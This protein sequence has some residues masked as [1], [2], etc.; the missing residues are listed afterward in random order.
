MEREARK[1]W[2]AQLLEVLTAGLG[3]TLSIHLII[4]R[5]FARLKPKVMYDFDK[6]V[7]RHGTR[8][9]K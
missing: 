5:N 4:L 8:Y 2:R 6:L 3:I 7:G 9:S 1:F